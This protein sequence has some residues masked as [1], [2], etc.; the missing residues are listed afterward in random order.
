MIIESEMEQYIARNHFSSNKKC[1]EENELSV[2]KCR[3]VKQGF[4]L[5]FKFKSATFDQ[6]SASYKPA[7]KRMCKSALSQSIRFFS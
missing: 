5:N 4:S 1:L 3:D 6:H 7:D 2:H